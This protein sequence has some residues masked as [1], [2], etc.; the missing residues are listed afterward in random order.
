[1]RASAPQ[2]TCI[3]CRQVA[4]K[5]DLVR[6]VVTGA[7]VKLDLDQRLPGRGAY[8]HRDIACIDSAAR[9]GLNRS[10]RRGFSPDVVSAFREAGSALLRG[11]VIIRERQS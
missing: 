10:F 1:M 5:G 2:R 8:V 9:G 4:G 11:D 6:L 7:R 3:G